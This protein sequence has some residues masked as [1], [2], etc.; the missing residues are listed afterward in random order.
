ME[1]LPFQLIMILKGTQIIMILIIF[2][3][4][5]IEKKKNGLM[6]FQNI[7]LLFRQIISADERFQNKE[8]F[9]QFRIF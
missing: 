7:T 3:C 9:L 4:F 2:L 5:G 1:L 8:K 6:I